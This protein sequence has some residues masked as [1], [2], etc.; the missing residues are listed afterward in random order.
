MLI[1]SYLVEE[2]VDLVLEEDLEDADQVF[3]IIQHH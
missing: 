1:T 2:V 3:Q